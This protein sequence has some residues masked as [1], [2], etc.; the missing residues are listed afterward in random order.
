MVCDGEV[1]DFLTGDGTTVSYHARNHCDNG[2]YEWAIVT[3]KGTVTSQL[4][5]EVFKFTEQ[6]KTLF[7]D[8]GNMDFLY[9]RDILVGNM[10]THLII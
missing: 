3:G 10:G 4:T 9:C 7:N 1:I 2:K 5:G 6:D 8:E